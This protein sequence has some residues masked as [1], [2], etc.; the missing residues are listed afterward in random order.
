MSLNALHWLDF[1]FLSQVEWFVPIGFM[2]GMSLLVGIFFSLA[3]LALLQFKAQTQ[4]SEQAA[5]Y[6]ARTDSLTGLYN[7]NYLETLFNQYK[8]NTNFSDQTFSLLYFDLDG[9]KKI[10]DTYG[11]SA[12]DMVL[13]K[14]AKRLKAELSDQGD[15]VRIGGDEL[16]VFIRTSN[17]YDREMQTIKTKELLNCIE[18]PIND[19]DKT[20]HISASIGGCC[21]G[22]PFND[23]ENMLNKADKL[24]YAAKQAGGKRIYFSK[25]TQIADTDLLTKASEEKLSNTLDLI[26]K[27]SQLN[28]IIREN[29]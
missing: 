14:I 8:Q 3:V 22:K 21:F 25:P 28:R 5:I 18:L 27:H 6:A 2:L 7:R 20:Y 17:H 29:D 23:L 24:M 13:K 19:D 10:N 26:P 16:I 9:F 1:P 15:A 11:H 4:D 12:G